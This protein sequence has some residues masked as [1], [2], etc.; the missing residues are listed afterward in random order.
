MTQIDTT[1]VYMTSESDAQPLIPEEVARE[2]TAGVVEGSSTL[3]LFRQLPRMSSRTYR[4]PVL[5]SL[6]GAAFAT[7]VTSDASQGNTDMYSG[8][9]SESNIDGVPAQKQTHQMEWANVYIVAEP[10]AII[11]PIAEDVLDDADYPIWDEIRPRI[12]EAFHQRIDQA[13]I[14][15]QNRPTSWPIGI[16]P[17]ALALGQKVEEGVNTENV[18]IADDLADVMAILEMKGYDPSGWIGAIEMKNRLRKLRD[19]NDALLFSPSL[20]AGVPSTLFGLPINFPKNNVFDAT[21]A[22]MICGDM[23]KA[24][25]AIRNDITFKVFT[26]GVIQDSNGNIIMNLMQNDMVALRVTMR[27]GWAV[28]N[29]IHA[30][31]PDRTAAYPFSVLTPASAGTTS[32]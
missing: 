9:L 31:R 23:D 11:L 13:V 27:L 1:G 12:I 28:P 20:Q 17:G 2:I 6:G 32:P 8:D 19:T 21:T 7:S 26:E 22:L 30:M 18:D 10:L 25:Y 3:S 15:G 16:V 29:P 24:V 14:W 4:M 5:D